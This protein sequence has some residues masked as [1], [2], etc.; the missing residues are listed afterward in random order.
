MNGSLQA[1]KAAQ[2]LPLFRDAAGAERWLATQPQANVPAMLDNLHSQIEAFGQVA[3]TPRER[4]RALETLRKAVFSATG[5]SQR[6]F[7]SKPLPLAPV[8]QDTLDAVCRLWKTCAVAYQICVDACAKGDPALSSRAARVAHRVFACLRQEQMHCYAAGVEP[9]PDF[10][11]RLHAAFLAAERL[12]V[13]AD[14]VEDR[15]LGETRES[16]IVGQYAMAVMLYLARPPMLASGHFAAVVRWLVRWR[17]QAAVLCAPNPDRRGGE[18][19]LDL[20][21]AAPIDNASDK[22][23]LPRWLSLDRVLRKIRSR[24]AALD[25]G[26]APENLKLGS[27]LPAATC[28]ML[29][30][31]LAG[32]LQRPPFG[33]AGV[34]GNM[35]RL[36]VGTGLQRIHS[37]MGGEGLHAELD[38]NVS[39]D[40]RLFKEQLAV[41]GHVVREVAPTEQQPLESWRLALR[42][43]EELTLLRAPDEGSSRLA[44][45]SLLAIR[46]RDHFLLAMVTG[47]QQRDD[48]LLCAVINLFPDG[49]LPRAVE[50]RDKTTGRVARH[51]AF[52]IAASD[53]NARLLL[54]PGGLMQRAAAARIFDAAG[55]PLSGLRLGECLERGGDID[56]WSVSPA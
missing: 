54:I 20:A 23:Q 14:P 46:Q 26:E 27:G 13:S 52:E 19:V 37:L 38:P 32:H 17:E 22:P 1:G 11:K 34:S 21:G 33:L 41:F 48:G 55:K 2:N 47:I 31:D 28:R 35:P 44:L 4:F 56:V 53:G 25:A 8:E 24:M 9:G 36:A 6:R 43:R 40:D 7:E 15:L 30:E 42:E 10:W 50:V 16:T 51:P 5:A 3:V 49:A 29:L 45:R 39:V 12:G 18:V